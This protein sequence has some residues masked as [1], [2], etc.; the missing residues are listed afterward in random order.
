M[1]T[2]AVGI[3]LLIFGISF[4]IMWL[5][6]KS[7]NTVQ[8]KPIEETKHTS[9]EVVEESQTSQPNQDPSLKEQEK[10]INDLMKSMSLEEK[11]GQLFLA[12]VPIEAQQE[13][14][15][16]YH[17]G[18]YL[19]FGRDMENETPNSL[20]EKISSYQEVSKIPLFIASDE[21][22]GTVSRLSG[23]NGL[24]TEPFK[25]PMEIYQEAGLT[26]IRSDIQQKSAVLRSYGIQVG[27]FPDADV[28]TDPEAFIYDRTIGVDAEKTS[29]YVKASV[30]A[31]K[32][33]QIA[34]TLKHFPG[35]GDNRDSHVEIVY[36]TRSLETL[37]G[38]DFLPFKAGIAAGTDSIMVSHNIVTSIDDTMPASISQPVHDLLRN[39]LGFQGVIMTDDMDMAGLADFITQE[40]AGLAALKSGNDLILSSSFQVQIPYV[41]QAI[42]QGSY[43]EEALNQS[44]YRVLKMKS[45]LGLLN[46]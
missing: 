35:Y 16:E 7:N 43:S 3:L 44:V 41:I 42:E 39:E 46:H 33:Q 1:I 4:S 34:S 31:L 15:Q 17:L 12:R 11:V 24:V 23:G 20:K 25:S 26:G 22:G 27:L 14:L 40:E 6:N 2:S 45:D 10:K 30:E 9:T 36:D 19:L 5:V 28:A 18:G 29:E 8:T 38:N 37:R 32:K 21:E 13:S